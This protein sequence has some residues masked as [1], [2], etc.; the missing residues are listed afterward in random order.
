MKFITDINLGRLAIWLRILGYDTFF[1]RGPADRSFLRKAQQENR[2]VLTRKRELLKRQFQG[3]LFVIE[4]DR[5][6][7]QVEE[8]LANLDLDPSPDRYFSRCLRCNGLLEEVAE[9]GKEGIRDRVPLYVFEHHSRFTT[10]PACHAVYWPGTHSENARNQI[11]AL[12]IP[13]RRP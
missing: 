10:C 6:G 9:D 8:V 5:V 7:R 12:R 2:V 4:S 3:I 1:Y 13:S 11:K